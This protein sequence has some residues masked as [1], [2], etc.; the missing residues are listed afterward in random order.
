MTTKNSKPR[1]F[2]DAL[3]ESS[4]GRASFAGGALCVLSLMGSILG[5]TASQLVCQDLNEIERPILETV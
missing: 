3:I 1:S 5:A 4:C 2:H